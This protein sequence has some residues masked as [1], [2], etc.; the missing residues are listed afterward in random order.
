M[1]CGKKIVDKSMATCEWLPRYFLI[2]KPAK[3]NSFNV[4]ANYKSNLHLVLFKHANTS[5]MM[6]N[7]GL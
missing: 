5:L 7:S 1:Q 3:V 4:F 6:T 2:K